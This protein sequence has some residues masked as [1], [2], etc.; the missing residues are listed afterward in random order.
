MKT[1]PEIHDL[2]DLQ[3]QLNAIY[4]HLGKIPAVVCRTWGTGYTLTDN[5]GYAAVDYSKIRDQFRKDE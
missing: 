4:E 3:E 1:I 5:T 2:Q